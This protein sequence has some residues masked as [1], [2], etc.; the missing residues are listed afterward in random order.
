MSKDGK[1][2]ADEKSRTAQPLQIQ[3]GQDFSD[4]KESV[5][6]CLHPEI[7]RP[8]SGDRSINM[9][10]LQ[11]P[12]LRLLRSLSLFFLLN[13]LVPVNALYFYL[14]STTPKCFYEELPKGTLVV[15]TS[16]QRAHGHQPARLSAYRA[17]ISRL[18]N[19]KA[20]QFEPGQ[21]T[22]MTVP[23]LKIF[24][25]VDQTFDND[26]RVVKQLGSASGRFTF[27]AAEAGDHKIC[28][29]P[30]SAG[31]GTWVVGG[32]KLG[33]IKLTLDLVIGESSTIERNDKGKM[34][35]LVGK[36]KDLKGRLEDIRRE[37]VFQRVSALWQAIRCLQMREVS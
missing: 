36:V 28:F 29:T 14:D 12:P 27:T 3:I 35:D 2:N 6:A 15:G 33:N 26:H 37:Q 32:E 7:F 9:E 25:S 19:Y 8:L 21:N 10:R 17:L 20:E 30:S 16:I 5:S 1:W 31:K 22:Y 24:I 13:V 18:G 11:S 34:T 23:D 4:F